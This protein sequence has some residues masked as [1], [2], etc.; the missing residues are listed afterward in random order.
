MTKQEAIQKAYGEHWEKLKGYIDENGWVE[1][2]QACTCLFLDFFDGRISSRI[3]YIDC[4]INDIDTQEFFRPKSLQGIENN[5]GWI[6]GIPKQNGYYFIEYVNKVTDIKEFEDNVD[7][8]TW[9][10]L[11]VKKHQ[12]ILFPK[13]SIF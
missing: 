5:N 9:F 12:K 6:N 11:N 10:K 8:I 1:D 7:C 2:L 3:F 4:D 13:Q